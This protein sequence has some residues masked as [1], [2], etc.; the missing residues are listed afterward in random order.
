M[1]DVFGAIFP[2][3]SE[4][5]SSLFDQR[6][7]VFVKFSKF[8]KLKKGSK[9]VFY[10]SKEKKLVGEGKI[11]KVEKMNPKIAWVRYKKQIFL[12]ENE[13]NQYVEKSPI[14]GK[15]RKMTEIAIFMLKDLKR[16]RNQIDCMFNV[17]P[18]GRY[19]TQEEYQRIAK[20]TRGL[21]A[22]G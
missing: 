5:V 17:T 3:S 11:T 20:R 12:N 8:L 16:Y 1:R 9:I 22:K 14:S 4:N 13:Y 2:I 15:N 6:R 18:S 19:L 10:L 21:V 7:S